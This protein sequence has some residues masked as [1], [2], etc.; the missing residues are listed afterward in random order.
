MECV[1]VRSLVIP[2]GLSFSL[3][4]VMVVGSQDGP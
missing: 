4:K 2:T 1:V 3:S